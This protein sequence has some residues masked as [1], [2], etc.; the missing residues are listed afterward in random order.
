MPTPLLFTTFQ[1]RD[2]QFANRIVVSPMAQYSCVDGTMRDW[3]FMHL[4]NLAVSGAG[5]LIFEAT[6]VEAHGRVSPHCSGLWND[7]QEAMLARI[8]RF[9]KQNGTAKIGLQLAHAGRK[10]SVG[11]P[12]HGQKEVPPAQG[13]WQT[14]SCSDVPYPGRS[15]PHALTRSELD[16][17]KGRFVA[18]AVRTLR[19]G[20]DLIEIHGAHGYLLHSFLSPLSNTRNDL[21]GG[22]LEGRMRFP[23]EVFRAVR[24]AWPADKPIGYRISATDWAPGGWTIEDSMAFTAA[25]KRDG[26]DYVTASSGG[27]SNE[28]SIPVGPGYQLP[29]SERIR[30]E[31]H[32]PTM[33]VGLITDPDQ[34]EEALAGG[35]ADLIA[36]GRAMMYEPRWAWHAAE[37]LGCETSFPPQY[38]RSHPSMR[39]R[40]FL[41]ATQ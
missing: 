28:Q 7:N 25:L 38:A 24:Q 15:A 13:G 4:G 27:S 14:V 2:L 34:A 11:A 21:Y 18:A 9:C 40:D 32:I 29:F 26:C 39:K 36:L 19:A 22:D 33:G 10:A 17:L 35:K 23:L 3:N 20:F 41:K 6:A 1:L 31:A 8:V 16:A 12:W 30:K 37:K 5:L